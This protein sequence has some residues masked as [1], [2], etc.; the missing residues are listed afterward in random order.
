MKKY[1]TLE[2]SFRADVGTAIQGINTKLQQLIDAHKIE[3]SS[4]D[5]TR[6]KDDI[7]SGLKDHVQSSGEQCAAPVFCND[8]SVFFTE[9]VKNMLGD[10]VRQ[11]AEGSLSPDGKGIHEALGRMEEC[12]G[13][14]PD[15]EQ[16]KALQKTILEQRSMSEEDKTALVTEIS[17]KVCSNESFRF[18]DDVNEVLATLVE[19]K[20]EALKPDGGTNR[21]AV[22]LIAY[23]DK[24]LSDAKR[25][26]GKRFDHVA[27][28]EELE[29]LRQSIIQKMH[30][31]SSPV[32]APDPVTV[33]LDDAAVQRI[34]GLLSTK[35]RKEDADLHAQ[36]PDK[37]WLYKLKK[38]KSAKCSLKKTKA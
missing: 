18:T 13:R 2:P 8:D 24:T 1:A 22:A 27:T 7:V 15:Q 16:M 31:M 17:S 20:A 37:P 12:L 35:N 6:L 33:T 5:L 29:G 21:I 38:Q 25:D 11:K 23:I 32:D 28:K 10:L 30:S 14:L 34:V 26:V 4:D 19:Q 9:D 36:K 3:L